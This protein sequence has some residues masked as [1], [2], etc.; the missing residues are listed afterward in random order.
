MHL[1]VQVSRL[2]Q[3]TL[4][5]KNNKIINNNNNNLPPSLAKFS[6][7][8]RKQGISKCWPNNNFKNALRIAYSWLMVE[9]TYLYSILQA[10]IYGKVERFNVVLNKALQGL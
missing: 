3:F 10:F 2:K 4:F 5:V 8:D 1:G 7:G 9:D 6:L